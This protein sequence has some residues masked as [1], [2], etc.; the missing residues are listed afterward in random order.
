MHRTNGGG[1]DATRKKHCR[2]RP[3]D[4]RYRPGDQ[5]MPDQAHN[6]RFAIAPAG[7]RSATAR[8]TRTAPGPRRATAMT[9]VNNARLA[10]R[11][12]PMITPTATARA[13]QDAA[14]PAPR[15]VTVRPRPE[16]DHQ[17]R[18]EP[19][20]RCSQRRGPGA[21]PVRQAAHPGRRVVVRSG[22]TLARWADTPN[23]APPSS[24]T[25]PANS[26]A[27]ERQGGNGG[28]DAE[29]DGVRQ[30]GQRC[31]LQPRLYAQP[32]APP[33][34]SAARPGRPPSASEASRDHERDPRRVRTVPAGDRSAGHRLVGRAARPVPGRVDGYR[35]TSRSTA[36]RPTSAATSNADPAGRQTGQHSQ[37]GADRRHR[38]VGTG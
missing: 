15:P 13:G 1:K 2:R 24:P 8:T 32:L 30:P 19:T 9:S 11:R 28:Q 17:R 26:V 35:S 12:T 5:E 6:G 14:A 7:I 22:S 29:G 10:G 4:S 33:R 20:A 31:R 38:E 23:S 34:S 27:G 36:D 3:V 16:Q 25:A 21:E 18:G 37:S